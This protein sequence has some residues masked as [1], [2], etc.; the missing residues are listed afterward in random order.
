MDNVRDTEGVREDVIETEGVILLE[1]DTLL[2]GVALVEDDTLLEDVA[3]VEDVT[4]TDGVILLEDVILLERLTVRDMD[5]LSLI[6]LLTERLSED[7]R[8]EEGDMVGL[9]E[10]I[11][12]VPAKL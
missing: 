10:G 12:K 5:A 1:G 7:D 6:L 8:L 2:E 9:E 4:L 3:L 11:P